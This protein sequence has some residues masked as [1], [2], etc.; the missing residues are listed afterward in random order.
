MVP[1]FRFRRF[2]SN[3]LFGG[4]ETSDLAE[5]FP[6]FKTQIG[7]IIKKMASDNFSASWLT[8]KQGRRSDTK[9]GPYQ[10][11]QTAAELKTGFFGPPIVFAFPLFFFWRH[12]APYGSSQDLS[13]ILFK[14]HQKMRQIILRPV[15]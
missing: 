14:M 10:F 12:T 7:P 11:S 8:A 15:T 9:A 2:W 5:Y 4:K 1:C 13:Q 3:L 6:P